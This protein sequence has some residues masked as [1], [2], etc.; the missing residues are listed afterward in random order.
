MTTIILKDYFIF[1]AEIVA[2]IAIH[3]FLVTRIL[4]EKNIFDVVS[5]LIITTGYILYMMHGKKMDLPTSTSIGE[6]K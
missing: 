3:D 6:G 2:T 1:L 5:M 4:S